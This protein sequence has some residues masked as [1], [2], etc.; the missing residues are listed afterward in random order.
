MPAKFPDHPPS[1]NTTSEV[2][3]PRSATSTAINNTQQN[4]ARNI[5]QS[6]ADE[7]V[8]SGLSGR[9]PESGNIEEFGS[10][11][12]GNVDM[13]TDDGRR[14]TPGLYGLPTRSGKLKELDKF[15]ATFF[16][17]H[18]KQADLMDPQLRMLLEVT[19]EAIVDAGINP[20]TIR[21]S[22]TG[23]FIGASASES[24]E[25]WSTD[26]DTINGYGLT[27]CCRAMFA[28]R[29][30][31]TFDF[32]GPSFALDTACS[33]SLLALDQAVN[34]IRSGQCDAAIVGGVNLLLK[35]QSSLQFHRLSMLAPDGKC[36][37]F[38]IS[39]NGYVRSEAAVAIYIQKAPFANR[40]YASILHIKTNTDGHKEQ[41][42]TFPAGAIQQRLLEEVYTE[43]GIN[44]ATVSYVEAH[45]T[46][47]KVGDPQEL[48]S[49]AEVF[50]KGRDPN[51]PLL[52]GSVKSNMGHSE[53]ASGLCSIAKVVLAMQEGCIPSNLHFKTPNPDI[54]AL[55]DGRFKVV[56]ENLPWKGGLI[57]VNSFGF[58]GA[59]V[60]LVLKSNPK[61]K[62]TPVVDSTPVLVNFSGRTKEAVESALKT[63]A[64]KRDEELNGLFHQ[65]GK[66][67]IPG[68]H[69]RGYGVYTH[70][71]KLELNVDQVTGTGADKPPVWFVFSGMGSQWT[72][73]GKDLMQFEV[74]ETSL[75]KSHEVLKKHG[76]DLLE[77]VLN[78]SDE[79]FENVLNAFVS[80]AAV[81]IA[82]V[83]L[84]F[85]VGVTPDGIVGHSVGELG[86]AYADGCFTAEQTILA[87]FSRGRA[88]L[89]SKLEGGAMA[90]VGLT[91]EDAKRRC[92]EDIF[93][94]C[95][96]AKDSVS[97][98]GPV[99]SIKKFVEELKAEG[100][101][102]KEVKSSGQAFH[103]KYIG[104]AGPRLRAALDQIVTS[105]KPRSPRWISS[106][107]PEDKWETPLAK[108]SS[109][110]YHV[111]NLL[112]PVL[113]QEALGHVPENALVIEI[114]P[115]ALL[116]AILK[117]S[118]PSKCINV[119]LMNRSS[120]DNS[121]FF[122]TSL[123]KIFIAGHNPD[124]AKLYPKVD[125][126]VALGT[127]MISPLVQWDHSIS[128][129][130]AKFG[131][132]QRS[133]EN[134]IEVSLGN[135]LDA[136]IA[137]HCIDG[138]I[139]FPATGYM[140]LVWK[141][142]AKLRGTT[143]D[144]LPVVFE[145]VSFQRATI[146]QKDS[147]APTKFLI[148]ILEGSGEFEVHEGGSVAVS[149]YIHV[150]DNVSAE[151]LPLKPME[152][153]TKPK[154]IPL[155]SSDAYKELRLRGYDYQGLF[156]GIKQVDNK[157]DWG[158][159]AWDD[160]WVSYLDTML[161]FSILSQPNRGL[162]LP[163][164]L[165]QAVIDPKAFAEFIENNKDDVG[166]QGIP[167]YKYK[168]LNVVKSHGIELKGLK[169]SLA[170]R[171]QGAQSAP[172]L[173]EYTF[174]PYFDDTT[175]AAKDATKSKAL[176]TLV[177]LVI[178]NTPTLKLKVAEIAEK[179]EDSL[180]VEVHD[181]TLGQP[182][183]Q[184]EVTVL[185]LKSEAAKV[186]EQLQKVGIKVTGKD[187]LEKLVP[188]QGTHL[189]VVHSTEKVNSAALEGALKNDGFVLAVAK[190]GAKV[191]GLD[192]SKFNLV[193][194]KV[195]P[196]H[197]FYLYRKVSESTHKS[198]VV[199]NVENQKFDWIEKV[200]E[201]MTVASTDPE[202]PKIYLLSGH[203]P[204]S[205][206]LGLVNCLKQE[207]GGHVIRAIFT[208]NSKQPVDFAKPSPLLQQIV[209]HDLL[210]N[211]IQDDPT[212]KVPVLGSYRHLPLNEGSNVTASKDVEHAYINTLMRGDLSSLKWIEGPLKYYKPERHPGTELCH[213]YYAPLNFRDIMLATGKLPPD[214]L[215]GNLA[216]QDCVLG[217]EFAGK[218]DQGKR[219]MGLVDARG[220]ATT[221]LADPT[222]MWEV[223][224]EWSLEQAATVP[225]CYAT[226]YYALVVRGKLVPGET[227]LIH[228]GSG[229]VGQAAISIAL[230]MG[231]KVFTTIGSSDK[232]ELLK[233]L[234]PSLKEEN[235]ANS[236]DTSFEQHILEATEGR[237]V[238]IVLNSLAAEKLQASVRVLATHGRFL[239]IGK[240][241]LSQNSP[242]GM[243]VFLKNVTFHGIL[244][245]ALF[246]QDS[247]AK[248]EVVKLVADGIK[249]GAVKPL[250]S[251]VFSDDQ[252]EEAFRFMASGKHVGKVLLKIQ[253]EKQD[254]KA[255]KTVKASSKTY[256]NPEKSVIIIGG[257]GGFGL[258]LSNWLI[259]RGVNKLVLVS[260]SGVTTGYQ[261]LCI[262]RWREQGVTVETPK[263][264]VTTLAGAQKL[265]QDTQK[266]GSLGGIYNLAMVLRD[267]FMENQTIENFVAVTT[268]KINSTI[269]LDQATRQLCPD[270][271]QFVIF[272]SVSCGRGNAGQA[273]YGLANS[274]MERICEQRQK[275]GFPSLAIQW[276]AIGDV[277][278]VSDTMGGNDTVVGG[279]LPQ[280]MPSCL[281]ALDVFLQQS[282]PVVASM[283]LADKSGGRKE[284]G[285]KATLV[286]SVAHVLGMKDVSNV[287]GN[288]NLAELGMDS[289]MGVEVK[290]TLERDYDLVLSMQEIRQLTMNRLKEIDE[291]EGKEDALSLHEGD[292]LSRRSSIRSTGEAP[293]L[294]DESAA[295]I[296]LF[297][298]ELMPKE[299]LVKL[300][301]GKK[302]GNVF[303]VHPIE[304]V[305]L[306]LQK[307]AGQLQ[308]TVYGLQCTKEADL[309]SAESLAAFYIK[310]IKT[311][312]PK[313]PYNLAG[314]SYGCT[315][316]LEMALQLEKEQ[317]KQVKHLIFLDGSHKYV[318]AQ[319][320]E[321]KNKQNVAEIGAQNE[322]DALCTFL[323]QFL[324]FEYL[325]VRKELIALPSLDD[326]C[327]HIASLLTPILKNVPAVDIQ[328]AARSFYLK[329][330]A[331]D[332]YRASDKFTGSATLIKAKGNRAASI[333]GD[334]YSL[335]EVCSKVDIHG[336]DG[337]HRSFIDFPSV[338]KVAKI[339]NSL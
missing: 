111:N 339:I 83:D 28:N 22:N 254:A 127:P 116:Q 91:W 253:D 38:D 102:A 130:V 234:F 274:A 185:T 272:S 311:V 24:D 79:T 7:I 167:V 92:P 15:D 237:G 287:N 25:A 3:S 57:G 154:Y 95:H 168:N 115:H 317:K 59:N 139:L 285:K 35:P 233:K 70:D 327:K 206:I 60:H 296:K 180:A 229:G 73:M 216:M 101:F 179:T 321:Y 6:T 149:G 16:G 283:V 324:S 263:L 307:L 314:Y 320:E 209:K 212:T 262:R 190:S 264:D 94:A 284:G 294:N 45:G 97:I 119:G 326:R 196:E 219:L 109:S 310:Q 289:L 306:S 236:R 90:A 300:H 319:T 84:L 187:S 54:P 144:Q 62:P 302:S 163:T 175:A 150:P 194:K 174:T 75:R 99:Q 112:S 65:L 30:S 135:E 165:Q 227:V 171:R 335:S 93:P 110:A 207:P 20:S 159:L 27:G 204:S 17:V 124:V 122:L 107:I 41:G 248:R 48:N 47:T 322:S 140:F 23:V 301:A 43:A 316:A 222:F 329:L 242:L 86:C 292:N 303:V 325:K 29:I 240:F 118:L 313:G 126:P 51:N 238:D 330:L 164:R 218:N 278:V 305:T 13:I 105:P 265:I 188:D 288:A 279:T 251:T 36:K 244:L 137:G 328:D 74:F 166:E 226:A 52:I 184:D 2:L 211:I 193:A 266:L 210:V 96:N 142:L 63:V 221:V 5:Y 46:G 14:W 200:K 34:A 153:P 223:P 103:S 131:Q 192:S 170:P 77:V 147:T 276:G 246:D 189:I 69:F 169:A 67:D 4:N 257:L 250:P 72:G 11:M 104:A 291:G 256:F 269:A 280:R 98:S 18:A 10:N 286:E 230:S 293:D 231:C 239:E 1:P 318:S 158:K 114:A 232:K 39:G 12:F 88:I 66:H 245:D 55:S 202:A 156:R 225:V 191:E 214:A 337:N 106:S 217:L 37:A 42:I 259:E 80:I 151:F 61:N 323:M 181:I 197:E 267:G 258:E 76:F 182:M 336:V 21:G 136:Y 173:E 309:S 152:I 186:N 255:K 117:R 100:I 249:S 243:S 252:I 161:Q 331:V 87:A 160:N 213:V 9:L 176:R 141:T 64:A 281:N 247:A 183:Y 315:I 295:Q 172:K 304:G 195:A 203:N 273:N 49:I 120:P 277:G 157:G 332:K 275:D 132:G 89:E 108:L 53:P 58:G 261:D 78:G 148:N 128:W 121:V 32:K 198:H 134:I 178:E 82:L 31:Y 146:L 308:Q 143:Y 215:P 299:C 271:E 199:I 201:G 298:Q 133:G 333:L 138:R 145:N 235:F 155:S 205:G 228:S 33:S 260:R 81:Q 241:D 224:K 220:L 270:L 113:F 338:E 50:C 19:Y 162:Y 129:D 85:A 177:D 123:G 56:S 71:D 26:P 290:Q 125:F 312:Q 68:H 44:P 282:K 334:D 268:P 297:V 208:Q 40:S 8:I